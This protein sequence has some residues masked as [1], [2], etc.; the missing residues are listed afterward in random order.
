MCDG[1]ESLTTLFHSL[2]AM[3]LWTDKPRGN[4]LDGGARFYGAYRCKDGRY[5]SVGA[6]E[7]QFYAELLRSIGI[8][9]PDFKDQND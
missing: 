2:N 3:S 4:L 6:I 5:F 8:D 7:P 9:D 1:V